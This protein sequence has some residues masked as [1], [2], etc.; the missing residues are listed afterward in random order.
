MRGDSQSKILESS[1]ATQS[2][3]QADVAKFRSAFPEAT[4]KES[5]TLMAAV[6]SAPGYSDASPTLRGAT[7]GK[8]IVE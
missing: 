4:W 7:G 2:V 5:E 8:H 1:R 6:F 3:G